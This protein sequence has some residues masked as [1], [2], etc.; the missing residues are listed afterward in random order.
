MKYIIAFIYFMAI[1]N[2]IYG[3]FTRD[4]FNVSV[5]ILDWLVADSISRG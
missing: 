3:A 1:V 5:A 4:A 2:A